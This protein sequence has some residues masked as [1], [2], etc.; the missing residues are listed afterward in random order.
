MTRLPRRGRLLLAVALVAAV[1][2]GAAAQ[3]VLTNDAVIAMK[4]A[5]LSD[6]VILAKIRSSQS[7]FDVSTQALVGLKAAG[8]S[9]PIIEA[10]V[11]HTG[12]VA[13]A[14]AP[15][16]P[17]AA[18]PAPAGPVAGRDAIYHTSGD[19]YVELRAA[20]AEVETNFAFF[21]NKSELVLKGRRASYR[22]ADL[23]PVFLSTWSAAEAPLV[24]LK[25][26]DKHDDRNLKIGSGF[27]APFTGTQRLGVRNEDKVDVESEKDPRGFFRIRPTQDLTPGEYAFVVTHGLAA[28]AGKVYDFGID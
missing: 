11:S 13:G 21:Q 24:R 22:V 5:G 26:G 25:P 8:L 3:E 15:A 16:A 14:A 27:A 12:P 7:R 10:M 23:R 28:G 2:A 17:P 6:A 9:D 18:A 20:P 19:R 1:A 4:R